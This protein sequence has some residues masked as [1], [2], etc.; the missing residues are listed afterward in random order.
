MF[1]LLA[2]VFLL[3][4]LNFDRAAASS[5]TTDMSDWWWNPSESG[6]GVN[7]SQQ[8]D[9]LGVAFFVFDSN[10]KPVWYTAALNYQSSQSFVWSGDLYATQGPWFGGAYNSAAVT[11]TK[12][13]TATFTALQINSATLQYSINGVSVT[14]QIQRITFKN[15]NLSGNYIG[16]FSIKFSGC[17]NPA[18]E[19]LVD[20]EV[21]VMPVTHSGST[22]TV[23]VPLSAGYTCTFTG[24]YSQAGK[25]GEID[26]SY[27]CTD[28]TNGTFSAVEVTPT[29][30]GFTSRV[31]G[32]NQV[33]KWS[34]SLG[35][36]TRAQ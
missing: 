6:W 25:L 27:T 2:I 15:E 9:V 29:I 1:R 3:L 21:G 20:N 35:A 7:I 4:S 22:V 26:G 17:S 14:K 24:Q 16:G 11:R 33:C 36:I 19:G 12:V 23:T 18:Y 5:Y 10:Q 8:N 28:G 31:S 13:G 30:S 34:G 32:Q